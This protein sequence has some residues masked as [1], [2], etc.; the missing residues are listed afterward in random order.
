MRG[1]VRKLVL[2]EY[3]EARYRS[4]E[5]VL[6]RV[7]EFMM[8]RRGRSYEETLLERLCDREYAVDYLNA[9]LAG[10]GPDA[11]GTFLAALRLVAKAQA[12]PMAGFAFQSRCGCGRDS[13]EVFLVCACGFP[14]VH[15]A[16]AIQP[17]LRAVAKVAREAQGHCRAQGTLFVDELVDAL[18]GD[19]D[20]L[21]EIGDR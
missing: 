13:V 12:L 7:P 6:G 1:Q 21:G 4:R 8:G 3:A 11:T 5:G 9:V 2:Y 17:E 10:D 15:F 20:G 14:E 19:L 18:A 16:L